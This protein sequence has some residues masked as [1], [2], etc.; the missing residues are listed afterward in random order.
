MLL[1]LVRYRKKYCIICSTVSAFDI[2][3]C[4]TGS[5]SIHGYKPLLFRFR[6][7]IHVFRGS[8]S[9]KNEHAATCNHRL[10]WGY[11][12]NAESE[13]AASVFLR[14]GKTEYVS[15]NRLYTHFAARS[16]LS[17]ILLRNHCTGQNG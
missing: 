9:S 15:R 12:R 17:R 10:D 16:N 2:M 4:C 3:C 14:R 1:M 6:R 5:T 7:R 8:E 11:G 13:Q